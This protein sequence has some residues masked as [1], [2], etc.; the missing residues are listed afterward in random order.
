MIVSAVSVG[1]TMAGSGRTDRVRFVAPVI[2]FVGIFGFR[3]LTATF[4]ND[5]I[6][7]LSRARQ[8]LHGDLPVRD[9]IDPGF[10]LAL[11]VSAAIDWLAGHRLVG[12]ALFTSVSLAAAYALVVVVARRVSGSTL[13]AVAVALVAASLLP[14]LMNHHKVLVPAVG[15]YLAWR[16]ARSGTTG[17]AVG[18]GVFAGIATLYRHDHGVYLVPGL[19]VVLAACHHRDGLRVAARRSAARS[20]VRGARTTTTA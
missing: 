4:P 2:V 8:I 5:H 7:F 19:L 13:I 16:Y 11:Y 12:E 3:L 17:L 15:L 9:F 10:F 6:S 20:A 14:R 18:M 1:K